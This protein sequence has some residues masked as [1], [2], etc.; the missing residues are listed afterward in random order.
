MGKL[1]DQI[2]ELM[3][4]IEILREQLGLE[5]RVEA[6]EKDKTSDDG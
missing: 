1:M 6:L 2:K 4:D 3:K 5:D